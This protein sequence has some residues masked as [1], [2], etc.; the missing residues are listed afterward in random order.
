MFSLSFMDSW[1]LRHSW[2]GMGWDGNGVQCYQ[3]Y[4]LCRSRVLRKQIWRNPKSA[5]DF[6]VSW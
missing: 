1:R 5:F 4:T 2:D 6:D 3:R